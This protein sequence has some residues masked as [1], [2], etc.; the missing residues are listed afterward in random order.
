MKMKMLKKLTAKQQVDFEEIM[1]KIDAVVEHSDH[2]LVLRALTSYMFA[3]AEMKNKSIPRDTVDF[4]VDCF[5]Q[6]GAEL[7]EI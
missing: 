3:L 1:E 6:Y 4:C 2:R 5:R 7:Q